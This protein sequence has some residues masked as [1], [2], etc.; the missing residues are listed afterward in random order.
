L[1]HQ[2]TNVV[3]RHQFTNVV[4]RHQFTNVVGRNQFTN[5]VGRYQFTNVVGR[6]Q[7]T[8]VVGRYQFTNVV[9]RH[10]FT[11]V[12][13]VHCCHKFNQSEWYFNIIFPQTGWIA[14]VGAI[15]LM[16]LADIS[17]LEN[18]FHRVEWATLIFFAALFVLM[19]VCY[20]SKFGFSFI[21]SNATFSNI[22]VVTISFIGGGNRSTRRKPPTCRKSLTTFIT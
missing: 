11:N 20:I 10:Q 3:G 5:V 6:N 17:E 18:I 15:A 4:G 2:F 9:G 21:V 16:I 7:F 13:V 14:V 8:N 19:E 12:V 1:R 22:S